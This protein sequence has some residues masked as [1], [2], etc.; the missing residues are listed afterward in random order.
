MVVFCC[1]IK[2]ETISRHFL[3]FVVLKSISLSCALMS[4][5][6]KHDSVTL[7]LDYLGNIG[8]LSYTDHTLRT[9]VLEKHCIFYSTLEL[10][11]SP[12]NPQIYLTI[13]YIFS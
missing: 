6:S 13:G 3:H 8:S 4:L 12:L 5:L 11:I 1:N 7:C 10:C 9:A 2:S